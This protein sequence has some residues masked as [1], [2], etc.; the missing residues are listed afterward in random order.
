MM[1]SSRLHLQASAVRQT[2]PDGHRARRGPCHAVKPLP[3]TMER[4]GQGV[5]QDRREQRDGWQRLGIRGTEREC[6]PRQGRQ[7]WFLN[8]YDADAVRQARWSERPQYG[9]LVLSGPDAAKRFAAF[10]LSPDGQAILA[11][12]GFEPID[13][14]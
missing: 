2:N 8:P 7:S 12:R 11:K 1:P 4:F 14:P 3:E 13:A 6:D 9:L 10:V 5:A